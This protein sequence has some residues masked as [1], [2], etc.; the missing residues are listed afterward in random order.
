MIAQNSREQPQDIG[1]TLHQLGGELRGELGPGALLGRHQGFE[2]ELKAG[3][4]TDQRGAA[5]Q[6]V[7]AADGT[8]VPGPALMIETG[9]LS[10][11]PA[12]THAVQKPRSAGDQS[13]LFQNRLSEFSVATEIVL[14]FF[15]T[16][17]LAAPRRRTNMESPSAPS[18]ITLSPPPK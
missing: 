14:P 15:E 2:A 13:V 8:S 18:S 5:E 11:S 6:A 7:T 10:F 16:E 1:V 17:T 12:A 9:S 4:L 3:Q